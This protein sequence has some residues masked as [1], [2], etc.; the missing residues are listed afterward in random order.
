MRNNSVNVC[1]CAKTYGAFADS[2]YQTLRVGF[3]SSKFSPQKIFDILSKLLVRPPSVIS[4]ARY[5]HHLGLLHEALYFTPLSIK[6]ACTKPIQTRC[7]IFYRSEDKHGESLCNLFHFSPPTWCF[8]FHTPLSWKGNHDLLLRDVPY[9]PTPTLA[10]FMLRSAE[11]PHQGCCKHLCRTFSMKVVPL[12]L[13][14]VG[15]G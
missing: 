9:Q 14:S 7:L 11:I 8:Q 13:E 2:L 4:G 1:P 6:K 15:T 3:N 10:L 5:I 12:W